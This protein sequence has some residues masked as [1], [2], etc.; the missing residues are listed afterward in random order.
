MF[1]VHFIVSVGI[2]A[3]KAIIARV[4]GDASGDG[5]RFQIEEVDNTRWDRIVVLVD[6]T[7]VNRAKLAFGLF[8]LSQSR[9]WRACRH[10]R[11]E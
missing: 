5:L 4:V 1:G 7:T 9:K 11:E 2:E 3:A 8:V 10:R 6:S